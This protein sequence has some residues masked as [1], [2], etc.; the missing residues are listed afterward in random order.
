M[1]NWRNDS[2]WLASAGLWSR[3]LIPFR[4][5]RPLAVVLCSALFMGVGRLSLALM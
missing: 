1:L 4:A 5:T 2:H 3:S